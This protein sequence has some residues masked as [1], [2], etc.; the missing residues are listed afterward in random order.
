MM[1]LSPWPA[2]QRQSTANRS[3]MLYAQAAR[4][5]VILATVLLG[6]ALTIAR[7]TPGPSCPD[8]SDRPPYDA[9]T[10]HAGS[11]STWSSHSNPD[12]TGSNGWDHLQGVAPHVRRVV[13]GSSTS[14]AVDYKVLENGKCSQYAMTNWRLLPSTPHATKLH[15][16]G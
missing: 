6:L 4:H 12:M 5:R 11:R 2:Q 8:L 1:L 7:Q 15:I 3:G 16:I 13:V 10:E 9:T 14:G